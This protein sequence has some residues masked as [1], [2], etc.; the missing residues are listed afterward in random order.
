MLIKSHPPPAAFFTAPRSAKIKVKP[1]TK[2]YVRLKSRPL[3]PL[4]SDLEV[5]SPLPKRTFSI[6]RP[7][8]KP[9]PPQQFRVVGT[10]KP[11]LRRQFLKGNKEKARM[12]VPFVSQRDIPIERSLRSLGTDLKTF[13]KLAI[14]LEL[15]LQHRRSLSEQFLSN[16]ERRRRSNSELRMNQLKHILDEPYTNFRAYDLTSFS[17]RLSSL[18]F[19]SGS[20]LAMTKVQ[21]RS[22]NS[23][24]F[25]SILKPNTASGKRNQASI[26]STNTFSEHG[27][28]ITDTSYNLLL[29]KTLEQVMKLSGEVRCENY[30][31]K[32]SQTITAVLTGKDAPLSECCISPM[33]VKFTELYGCRVICTKHDCLSKTVTNFLLPLAL[34]QRLWKARPLVQEPMSPRQV[35][36]T[37]ATGKYRSYSFRNSSPNSGKRRGS[38]GFDT[39]NLYLTEVERPRIFSNERLQ[40]TSTT[41]NKASGTVEFPSK[42]L[43]PRKRLLEVACNPL[44]M[45]L[46]KQ[47]GLYSP[48]ARLHRRG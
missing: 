5:A 25:S 46:A 22:F 8:S 32:D 17:S 44:Q 15:K 38:T 42:M 20:Q 34:R 35:S 39:L 1:K 27:A 26:A 41:T 9:D 13:S 47:K 7:D 28:R 23:L 3:N 37:V 31:D 16:F 24:Q 36:A 10:A 21:E 12:D 45:M 29:L 40:S 6:D 18:F 43:L 14:A 4:S 2:P 48:A 30:Y 33:Q 19:N 11:K